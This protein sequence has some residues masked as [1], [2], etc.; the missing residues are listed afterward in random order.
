M[1]QLNTITKRRS[2]CFPTVV[3][4]HFKTRKCS[5]FHT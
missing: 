2:R 3:R 5:F 1:L 4:Y